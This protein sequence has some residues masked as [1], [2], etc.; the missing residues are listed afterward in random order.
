M[1]IDLKGIE[2]TY[3]G[4]RALRGV[5][6]TL[7][8]GEVHALLGENGAGKST[9]IKVLTGVER[10]DGGTLRVDG[11]VLG[12][13]SPAAAVRAGIGTVYQDLNL[14]PNLDATGNLFLG[15]EPRGLGGAPDRTVMRARAQA[16]F[17]DLG[18]DVPLGVPVGRLP[19]SLQQITAIARALTLEARVLVFDEPT[20]A[21]NRHETDRL[22]DLIRTLRGRGLAVV[23]VT[24]KLFE[25]YGV[26]DR[27]S[28][29]RDGANA[30]S[31]PIRD[32]APA[33]LTYAM[34]GQALE[35]MYPARRPAPVGKPTLRVEGLHSATLRGA[36]FELRPGE[37]LGL[38]GIEGSGAAELLRVLFGLERRTAGEV[39][40]GGLPARLGSPL[41]AI[42][43]G[44]AFVPADRLGEGNFSSMSVGQNV[45]A[46]LRSLGRRATGGEAALVTR[47]LK[48]LNVRTSGP[49]QRVTALS[50]GNQQKVIFARWLAAGPRV[51]LL[52]D[53]T[54]GVD[55]GAK[56]EIY[57]ILRELTGQGVSVL[58]S[59]S[60]VAEL[61]GLADRVV[62]V[63]D[64]RCVA[65]LEG[66]Q[67]S[68]AGVLEAISSR[69][70]TGDALRDGGDGVESR[71]SA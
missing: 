57:R 20:S 13:A 1:R 43:V 5:D 68:E 51:L 17:G 23:Y 59:S 45:L 56:A 3:G 65:E 44:L 28:I 31:G 11:Q 62:A 47:L 12:F 15:H 64:G 41:S 54:R 37:V 34:L 18:V 42:Q 71:I 46:V 25:V 6:L 67:L 26:A 38:A 30:A 55:V 9:L 8:P 2:K 52:D 24:H 35:Y 63:A 58:F 29:L 49:G 22:L 69:P 50:G 27:V 10:P 39:E 33:E 21:L 53:P 70:Q 40:V 7:E 16:V 61:V 36:S 32:F 19:V 48:L 60:D 4:V 66:S 14:C